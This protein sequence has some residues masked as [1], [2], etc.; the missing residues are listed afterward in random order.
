MTPVSLFEVVCVKSSC[1]NSELVFLRV[2]IVLCLSFCVQD[3]LTEDQA[4]GECALCVC[5]CVCSR[6]VHVALLS[7]GSQ[8]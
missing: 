3:K 7:C 4:A 2:F 5:V 1:T 6:V 8:F